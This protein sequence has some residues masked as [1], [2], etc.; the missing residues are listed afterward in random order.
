M[1]KKRKDALKGSTKSERTRDQPLNQP[2]P[3]RADDVDSSSWRSSS[4]FT[5]CRSLSLSLPS[6]SPPLLWEIHYLYIISFKQRPP[7]PARPQPHTQGTVRRNLSP[8]CQ[9]HADGAGKPQPRSGPV[10][11]HAVRSSYRRRRAMLLQS[12]LWVP[13]GYLF[14]PF[15]IL[16]KCCRRMTTSAGSEAGGGGGGSAFSQPL[17][18]LSLARSAPPSPAALSCRT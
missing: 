13:S 2:P 7:R 4:M 17:Y 18:S 10:A 14:H 6:S 11:L 3:A 9:A 5:S 15:L 12:H 1:S 16:R 8:G